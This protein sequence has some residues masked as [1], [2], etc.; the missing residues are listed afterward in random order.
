MSSLFGAKIKFFA[1][2]LTILIFGTRQSKDGFINGEVCSV[3]KTPVMVDDQPSVFVLLSEYMSR[4][5]E[6]MDLCL[7]FQKS[8]YKLPSLAF[9]RWALKSTMTYL[10]KVVRLVASWYLKNR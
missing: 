2:S 5:Q 1:T 10:S 3:G 9:G 7:K 4:I 6:T 8:N